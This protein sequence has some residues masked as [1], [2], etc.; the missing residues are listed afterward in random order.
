MILAT[1]LQTLFRFHCFYVQ[2]FKFLGYSSMKFYPCIHSCNHHHNQYTPWAT[3]PSPLPPATIDPHHNSSVISRM[4]YKYNHTTRNL[5]RL[6]FF[7]SIMP[8]RFIQVDMCIN[9]SC[10][11]WV[12]VW[13]LYVWMYH[14]FCIYSPTKWHFGCFQ[15]LIGTK[16]AS[17]NSHVQVYMWP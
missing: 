11:C 14:T 3:F 7:L 15:L 8:L 2:A 9:S 13:M 4:W 1:E 16:K 10:F 5:L 6:A 17:V 12:V